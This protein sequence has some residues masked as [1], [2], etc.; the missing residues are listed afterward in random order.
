M[1]IWMKFAFDYMV[2]VN[3]DKYSQSNEAADELVAT[4]D[5]TLVEASP[6]DKSGGSASAKMTPLF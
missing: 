6:Y 1:Q 5:K 3:Y 4:G 2:H